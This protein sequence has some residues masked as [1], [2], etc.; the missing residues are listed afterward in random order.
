MIRF[1]QFVVSPRKMQRSG[2]R[3]LE[4]LEFTTEELRS[5]L[6]RIKPHIHDLL[7]RTHGK[8]MTA[9][10]LRYEGE[11]LLEVLW[12]HH[13][14]WEELLLRTNNLYGAYQNQL[15]RTLWTSI[16]QYSDA[17][18]SLLEGKTL[19]IRDKGRYEFGD[20]QSI[21]KLWEL[22]DTV[23]DVEK[24]ALYVEDDV[25][26]NLPSGHW[27]SF[28]PVIYAFPGSNH[29]ETL[30][31]ANADRKLYIV[32]FQVDTYDSTLRLTTARE[33]AELA[34]Y[35][36]AGTFTGGNKIIESAVGNFLPEGSSDQIV[37]DLDHCYVL[38]YIGG[39]WYVIDRYPLP[40]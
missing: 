20:V 30:S 37:L 6:S 12:R 33:G 9:S 14:A 1:E 5:L 3:W 38:K 32:D 34:I 19:L 16:L 28:E 11:D 17:P 2:L 25:V 15:A 21:T 8:L 36:Q 26:T 27:H 39:A 23:I 29:S 7:S 24:G 13:M 35:A 40:S 31:G 18:T 10:I 4:H 22:D